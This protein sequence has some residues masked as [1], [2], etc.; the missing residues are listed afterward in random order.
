MVDKEWIVE[1]SKKL[2]DAQMENSHVRVGK[3][4]E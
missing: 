2:L 4:V 1:V 3:Y